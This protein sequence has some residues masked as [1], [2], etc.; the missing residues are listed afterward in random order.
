MPN[1]RNKPV[2]QI[3]SKSLPD[4]ETGRSAKISNS[5]SVFPWSF[6]NKVLL[7]FLIGFAF[8]GNSLFN[9]YA[10]DDSIAIERNEFVQEGFSGIEKMLTSDAY[11]SFYNQMH[12]DSRA[13]YSGGR[14]R[15]LSYIIF[16]IE[17]QI[18]GNS[19]F[20]RHLV[21][22]LAF[23]GCLAVI[24]YFLT[25]FLLRN[26]PG[27]GDISFLAALLFAIHPIHT[28][29]VANIKSIDEILSLI[30]ILSTF[31]FALLYL[32]KKK[33][34]YLILGLGSLLLALLAKEYA[35]TLIVL[36]P[37]LF[38]LPGKKKPIEALTAALPYYG[39]FIIY[40]AMRI[41]AVGIPHSMPATDALID[42]FLYASKAQ[43]LATECW[44]LGKDM[45]FLF[46]PYPLSCDYSYSQI[47]Y[48]SFGDFSVILSILLYVAIGL[49]AL[50]LLYKRSVL[51]F[52]VLFFLACLAL[53]SNFVIELGA[54][55][56][57]RLLFHASFGF[58]VVLSYFIMKIMKNLSLKKKQTILMAG[59]SL[60]VLLCA[61]ETIPRNSQW[62]DDGTLFLHDVFVCPNS[63][64]L[65]NNVGWRYLMK[66]ESNAANPTKAMPYID[67]AKKYLFKAIAL[68][69]NYVAAYL[70]L[71]YVYYH[72]G[73]PDSANFCIDSV[74]AMYPMH[75]SIANISRLIAFQY[76]D[77]FRLLGAQH[78]SVDAIDELRKG[79]SLQVSDSIKAILWYNM[80]GAYFT[81]R[82]WNMARNA[83]D[84][85]LHRNPEYKEAQQGLDALNRS[86]L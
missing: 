78:K 21:N 22:V 15:P 2:R 36:L 7:L 72:L 6:R 71:T 75:P 83:W 62:K 56:G 39:V 67:S 34:K 59:L 82:N 14:Y 23:L 44:A 47:Q 48:H 49:W 63:S 81:L 84:S 85:A 57:E 10:H 17:Q 45:G 65:N 25:F 18:F 77:K 13:Q 40:L 30:L 43:K 64:L 19:P 37:L 52:P 35:I 74:R 53:I 27:G 8:Y 3:R 58:L 50:Q 16:A 51:A 5:L 9:K 20:V 55:L 70:N 32:E 68:K 12:A 4:V 26:I 31:I 38:Y 86:K 28:E 69:Q 66:Y 42:P 54:I 60:L 11:A 29:V 76:M 1:H 46:F 79:L 73:N 33:P 80:G 61:S 41:H 24:L